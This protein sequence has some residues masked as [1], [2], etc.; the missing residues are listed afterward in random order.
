MPAV[1]MQA[2]PC[3]MCKIRNVCKKK[4]KL[5]EHNGVVSL[6]IF[7]DT[8]TTQKHTTHQTFLP[9]LQKVGIFVRRTVQQPLFILCY[10]SLERSVS[11]AQCYHVQIW[12]LVFLSTTNMMERKGL[13]PKYEAQWLVSVVNDINCADISQDS[14]EHCFLVSLS[15]K[16]QPQDLK[17]KIL[18]LKTG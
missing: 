12:P 5:W 13:K 11:S 2:V 16:N 14:L 6:V 4:K 8:K 17:K 9:N 15:K 3:S 10:I 1:Y 18:L 7:G